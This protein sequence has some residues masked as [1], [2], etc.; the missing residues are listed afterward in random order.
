VIQSFVIFIALR[1]GDKT[2]F[3]IPARSQIFT[4][5]AIGG[6]NNQQT[7]M[8]L[9]LIGVFINLSLLCFGQSR[10]TLSEEF[11]KAELQRSL[12]DTTL[13]NNI[14][15][16]RE[17]LKD[18]ETA[19]LVAEQIL[20]AGYGRKNIEYQK[21]YDIYKIKNYWIVSG[22]LPKG[23][24]GGTFLI[25]MDARDSRVIRLTHGK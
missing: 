2:Q 18:K 13:H 20:F 19:I 4:L 25:I 23:S 22:T 1:A 16:K 6:Q 3:Q 8:R 24:L 10:T 12:T 5:W 14:D 21:P 17:I 9:L 7:T 15:K 11:A